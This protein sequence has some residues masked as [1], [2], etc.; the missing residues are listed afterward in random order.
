MKTANQDVVLLL[1]CNEIRAKPRIG[2]V[3]QFK[4]VDECNSLSLY[5]YIHIR[6]RTLNA[7]I[8]DIDILEIQHIVLNNTHF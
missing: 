8:N 7:R 4:P 1:I 6:F 5:I 3:K 2:K